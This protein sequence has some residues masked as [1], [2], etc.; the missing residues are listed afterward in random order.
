MFRATAP[1]FPGIGEFIT[2]N[3]LTVPSDALAL[4]ASSV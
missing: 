4:A 3:V 2:Q 1:D